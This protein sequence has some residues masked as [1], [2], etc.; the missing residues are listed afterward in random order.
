MKKALFIGINYID[1]PEDRLRGCIND[2]TNM[3]DLLNQHYGYAKEN[4]VILTDDMTD[5]TK[6]PTRD[7]ILREL[8]SL[9]TH[10]EM[11]QEIW[12]HY[13]GH[14]SWVN[15]YDTGILV[16]C[17]HQTAGFI[18]DVELYDIIRQIQ[19]KAMIM[20]DSCNSA[21]V[22]DLEWNF[23][24]LYGNK[25]MRVQ[26]GRTDGIL[27]QLT[28]DSTISAD[29]SLANQSMLDEFGTVLRSA[30]TS[31]PILQ[32][33]HIVMI[34]GSKKTENSAEMKDAVTQTYEGAF[35]DA[36]VNV[37]KN[38][39]YH[40]TLGKLVQDVCIWLV[41]HGITEQKPIV[42]CSTDEPSWSI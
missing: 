33:P 7:N 15:N 30:S 10:S 41:D 24:Y 5:P 6:R 34:S 19:C 12:I 39:S 4:M 37:L 11:Y 21:A 16:P 20:I 35:T 40:I 17:D 32:N 42:S 2:A 29:S 22:C 14:G 1:N 31:S 8:Q 18:V 23:E 38:N 26:L 28:T 13:S 9:A 3:Y 36:V 25:F 27:Q